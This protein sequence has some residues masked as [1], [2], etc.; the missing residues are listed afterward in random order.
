MIEDLSEL[1]L[2]DNNISDVYSI[3]KQHF[4]PTLSVVA[5]VKTA[6]DSKQLS[7]E[8]YH[9]VLKDY[10]EWYNNKFDKDIDT[11]FIENK[12]RNTGNSNYESDDFEESECKHM[13]GKNP[14][15]ISWF[16]RYGGDD[17]RG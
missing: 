3:F 5:A 10:V 7:I 1:E 16:I 13:D 14:T 6:F 11:T 12:L 9:Q 17:K 2:T 15:I 4:K 8:D